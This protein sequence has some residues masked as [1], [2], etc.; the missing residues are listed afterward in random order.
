[1]ID[2]SKYD[3]VGIAENSDYLI[4]DK[5][6][7]LLDV[8][9]IIQTRVYRE[10]VER[11]KNEYPERIYNVKNWGSGLDSAFVFSTEEGAIQL[12]PGDKVV[13]LRPKE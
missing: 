8:P 10:D 3:V 4:D 1:M 11:W 6:Q 7:K 5:Q 12:L 2:L 13:V 9:K